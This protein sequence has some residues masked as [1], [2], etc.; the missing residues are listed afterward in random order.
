[1]RAERKKMKKKKTLL[2]KGT[3]WE[4]AYWRIGGRGEGRWKGAIAGRSNNRE[5]NE[6]HNKS[7]GLLKKK[8]FKQRRNWKC[9][10]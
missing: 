10:K 4:A 1:M 5:D 3:T 7:F 9:W 2:P 6:E 8:N